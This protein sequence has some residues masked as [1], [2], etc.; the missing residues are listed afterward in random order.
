[1]VDARMIDGGPQ[2]VRVGRDSFPSDAD[3][4]ARAGE[5]LIEVGDLYLAEDSFDD[6]CRGYFVAAWCFA[7]AASVGFSHREQG[8]LAHASY[9]YAVGAASALL[10]VKEESGNHSSSSS[11]ELTDLPRRR[12]ER[13]NRS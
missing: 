7:Q 11:T 13:H 3:G 9:R 4:W 10:P 6:A 1:M 8:Y 2:P 5:A 12:P